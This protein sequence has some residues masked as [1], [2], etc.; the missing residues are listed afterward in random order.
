MIDR[1]QLPR[2]M[3]A[4][5]VL[6]MV[7]VVLIA[8]LILVFRNEIGEWITGDRGAAISSA[9]TTFYTCPMD[10][11]VESN[12]PDTCPICGMALT[13]VTQQERSSGVVRVAS[14]A[15]PLIGLDVAPVQNQTLWKRIIGSGVITEPAAR[16]MP[17]AVRVYRGDATTA[18]RGEPVVVT[19][20]DVPLIEFNGT[21]VETAAAATGPLR[22]VIDDPEQLLR[23]GMF[24]ELKIEVELPP[25]LTIPAT[26]VMYAGKRRLVFV[27]RIS[28]VFEPR[29]PELGGTADGFVEV[30]SGLDENEQVAVSGTFLLAAESRIRSDGTLWGERPPARPAAAPAN[31]SPAP[32]NPPPV[33]VKPDTSPT[34]NRRP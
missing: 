22:V 26:A 32:A 1:L 25:R 6:W 14:K 13:P 17:L 29:T 24:A 9:P 19:T 5:N 2:S 7:V 15:R 8:A 4:S 12:H 3:R 33:P 10:P 31:P 21:V 34:P 11:S 30:V 28:G 27:E 20:R 18:Q 23:P 16:R